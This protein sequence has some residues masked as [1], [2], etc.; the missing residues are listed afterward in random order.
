MPGMAS[1]LLNFKQVLCLYP[2]FRRP[3][4]PPSA[5]AAAGPPA[6]PPSCTYMIHAT[7]I[8]DRL[9]Q[10]QYSGYMPATNGTCG[11]LDRRA[12][13]QPPLPPNRP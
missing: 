9:F 2:G 1:D 11:A 3:P 12:P 7:A 6:C 8:P 5:A 13:V 4:P 10:F